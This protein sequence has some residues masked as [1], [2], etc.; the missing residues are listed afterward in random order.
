MDAA[1]GPTYRETGFEEQHRVEKFIA[2]EAELLDDHR[3]AEWIEL[4]AADIHYWIPTRMTRTF[5]ERNQEIAGL[6]ENAI[7]DDDFIALR[8]R[9]R[10][11]TSGQQWSEEPPSRT[12]R[13]ITNVRIDAR[14]D[15]NLDVRS[16]FWVYRSRLERH[17]DWFVGERFDTLR[18]SDGPYPYLIAKRKIVFEQS[19]LLS[20][21]VTLFL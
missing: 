8:G 4:F 10:R 2:A 21:S 9:V 17:Q 7:I 18:P 20:P 13:L 1:A 14:A 5:R 6:G 15:G 11:I 19:T 3:Y 12:R 16:N